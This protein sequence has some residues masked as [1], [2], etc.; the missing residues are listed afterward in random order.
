MAKDPASQP[1]PYQLEQSTLAQGQILPKSLSLH[2]HQD[3]WYSNKLILF[4]IFVSIFELYA[5]LSIEGVCSELMADMQT[6]A[7]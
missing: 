2:V 3:T 4:S 1:N 7:G 5:G 6:Y